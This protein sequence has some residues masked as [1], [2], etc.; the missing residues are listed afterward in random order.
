MNYETIN[1]YIDK[2]T[3]KMEMHLLAL[4]NIASVVFFAMSLWLL[5]TVNNYILPIVLFVVLIAQFIYYFA[6]SRKKVMT[7]YSALGVNFSMFLQFIL[8]IIV[9]LFFSE[10][11]YGDY[12]PIWF[13]GVLIIGVL[14]IFWGFF[15]SVKRLKSSIGRIPGMEAVSLSIPILV[16]F[17][18]RILRKY[19]NNNVSEDFKEFYHSLLFSVL[20]CI[21]LFYV[22]KIHVTILYLI[23]KYKIPNRKIANRNQ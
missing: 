9:G 23:K 21:M 12:D 20:L 4:F 13:A 1:S 3:Q 2:Y 6:I 18:S 19:I 7:I 11:T 15:C 16:T 17:F 22:G 8:L 14:C 5:L 10:K